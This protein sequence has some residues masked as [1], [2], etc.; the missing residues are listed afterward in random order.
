M[1]AQ[2]ELY[3]DFLEYAV[4]HGEDLDY[5]QGMY[6]LYY[7]SEGCNPEAESAVH[8]FEELMYDFLGVSS[9]VD[10][11]R[12]YD[13]MEAPSMYEVNHPSNIRTKE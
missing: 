3:K 2:H 7:E 13:L 10:D 12:L 1:S 9:V 4:E 11:E 8:S 6:D 5:V